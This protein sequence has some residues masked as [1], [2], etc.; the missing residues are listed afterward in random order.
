MDEAEI[1]EAE[2]DDDDDDGEADVVKILMLGD[3]GVG[4]TCCMHSFVEGKFSSTLMATAGVEFQ[5][6]TIRVRTRRGRRK[7]SLQIWDTA[8]QE[9]F[10]KITRAFY[11][12]TDGVVFTYDVSDRKSF[13][14]LQKWV[15]AMQSEVTTATAM[16][17]MLIGNKVDLPTRA[18]RRAARLLSAAVCTP[19]L[20][21]LGLA[22]HTLPRV[23]ASSPRSP[24]GA[25]A[26]GSRALTTR[27]ANMLRPSGSLV[28]L[29]QVSKE[30]GQAAAEEHG[31]MYYETSAKTGA[32]VKRAFAAIAAE[33]AQVA[34]DLEEREQQARAAKEV[35]DA[36]SG[37]R[38]C[39]V[40]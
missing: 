15:A 38:R 11:K 4:K 33:V 3:S 26:A 28:S 17:T 8:G 2:L 40:S 1:A 12:N 37:K 36:A 21:V 18:V 5:M 23:L 22:A 9:R 19:L 29:S 25:P 6:K 39:K 35:E 7:V 31:M 24:P 34:E 27:H 20:L 16:Q 32:N 30:E 10:Q 14:N 13:D